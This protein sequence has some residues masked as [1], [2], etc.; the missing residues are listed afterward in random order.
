MLVYNKK[1][2]VALDLSTDITFVI[3]ISSGTIRSPIDLFI[4]KLLLIR[5]FAR[6]I[7]L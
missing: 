6:R 5:L 7:I 4:K 1:S 3:L 2:L